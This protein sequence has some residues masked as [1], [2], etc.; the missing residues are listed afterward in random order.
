MRRLK[1]DGYALV[2][3]LV[4][5]TVLTITAMGFINVVVNETDKEAEAFRNDQAFFAA[6]S[7]LMLGIHWLRQSISFPNPDLTFRPFTGL[8]LN[9]H[10]V[11][12][13]INTFQSVGRPGAIIIAEVYNHPTDRTANE[14]VKRIRYNG[15]VQM[16]FGY[17]STF[18]DDTYNGHSNWGGFYRRR[19]DGRFHMNTWI[20]I[21]RNSY[22][23]SGN[24]VIFE[25]GLVTA[26][27]D[28]NGGYGSG[29]HH[30]NNYNQGIQLNFSG[31]ASDCDQIF[32]N[33][34]LGN[35]EKI[36]LPKGLAS[37]DFQSQPHVDL[38]T[39]YD[40]GT[41]D[42][43][44]RPTLEFKIESGNAKAIYHYRNGSGYHH[45]EINDYHNKILI[46]PENLNVLG[47]V[48]GKVTVAT[49]K[50]RSIVPVDD[51]V[52]EDYNATENTLPEAS[53][54]I[55]GLV[56][57][58]HVI[59]NHRWKKNWYSG[60]SSYKYKTGTLDITASMIGV[61]TYNNVKGAEYWDL[62]EQCDYNLKLY[63]NH[64]LK[65]WRYPTRTSSGS[66]IGGCMGSI[67][68]MHDRR[69]IEDIN[70][71]GFPFVKTEGNPSLLKLIL[72]G[73][74]EENTI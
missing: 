62:Y 36:A 61:E 32:T 12:V 25:K 24:E 39:S 26:A 43:D 59:F 45:M 73:W 37:G 49:K 41:E 23:G 67:D 38:P 15:V 56:S 40:Y 69:L 16:S 3:A 21:S 28:Y 71:P 74:T 70:P 30:E 53:E 65:A 9:G 57:G 54:N 33:R 1:N 19:F 20:E 2:A 10:F 42:N 8:Q 17:F 51:I 31:G 60:N 27:S 18:F 14:F 68:Y 48:R 52:Y 72:G 46:C 66:P 4:I 6:E 35:V 58:H 34:Y 55:L 7:G 29:S 63:G 50:G 22:P 47:T 13:V 44:Y 64:I 11:D 5:A